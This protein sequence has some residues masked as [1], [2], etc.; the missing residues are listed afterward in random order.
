MGGTG[1]LNGWMTN[2]ATSD[3][4]GTP[5]A[6]APN[7]SVRGRAPGPATVNVIGGRI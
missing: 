5:N 1:R 3:S 7:H 6:A 4:A 2:I